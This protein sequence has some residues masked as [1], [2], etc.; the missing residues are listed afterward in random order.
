MVED[1]VWGRRGADTDCAA[2]EE[3]RRKVEKLRHLS[4]AVGDSKGRL[5]V[6][7][8]GKVLSLKQE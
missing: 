2:C 7:G 3:T 5:Y 1:V 8:G 4:V 6:K